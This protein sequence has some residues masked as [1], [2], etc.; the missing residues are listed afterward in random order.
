MRYAIDRKPEKYTSIKV[1]ADDDE[2][3]AYNLKYG[4]TLGGQ[5][6]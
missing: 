5:T 3:V 1:N 2:I 4:T 6:S